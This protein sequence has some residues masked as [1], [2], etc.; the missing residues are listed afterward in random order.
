LP[1]DPILHRLDPLT[2]A[3]LIVALDA[4]EPV[5][6]A[7]ASGSEFSQQVGLVVG[8]VTVASSVIA[9]HDEHAGTGSLALAL[10]DKPK[11]L[12]KLILR[13][14]LIPIRIPHQQMQR[15]GREEQLLRFPP[16]PLS[17]EIPTVQLHGFQVI[18]PAVHGPRLDPQPMGCQQARV[19]PKSQ[20]RSH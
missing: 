9:T 20:Q 8:L 12:V 15:W 1:A 14:T 11:P 17:A 10:A 18:D 5:Q 4:R 2:P 13:F 16:P 19:M 7:S 6:N 3:T